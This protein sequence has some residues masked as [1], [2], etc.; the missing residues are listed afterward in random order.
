MKYLKISLIFAICFI[1]LAIPIQAKEVID[2]QQYSSCNHWGLCKTEVD[3]N[4]L[5]LT[6]DN[7]NFLKALDSDTLYD[8]DS[9]TNIIDF[10]IYVKDG[11]KLIITGWITKNTY[12]IA[13]I[14][15]ILIDPWWNET[16]LTNLSLETPNTNYN[17]GSKIGILFCGNSTGVHLYGLVKE[18][19]CDAT[20]CYLF[21]EDG[22]GVK[23]VSFTGDLCYLDIDINNSECYYGLADD[24]GPAYIQRYIASGGWP[25]TNAYVNGMAGAWYDGSFNTDGVNRVFTTIITSSTSSTWYDTA[26]YL[27]GNQSNV[28]IAEGTRLNA[29]AISNL[30]GIPIEYYFNGNLYNSSNT[31]MINISYPAI[32]GLYNVTAYFGNASTSDTIEYWVTVT[33]NASNVTNAT[34]YPAGFTLCVDNVTLAHIN[35]TEPLSLNHTPFTYYENCP[36]GCDN[37]TYS[38]MPLPYEQNL[39]NFGL[40]IVFLAFLVG[41]SWLYTRQKKRRR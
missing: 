19:N 11:E 30:T 14:G 35:V 24:G 28:T 32:P 10:N 8:L 33:A 27:E 3:I 37:V 39:Y 6:K 26:F 17:D 25:K 5:T 20:E 15:N 40:V 18:T 29:T 31:E 4:E 12:W 34:V 2:L 1:A 7:K 13:D 41:F 23:N 38:C 9:S 22:T 36:A 21:R 16:V